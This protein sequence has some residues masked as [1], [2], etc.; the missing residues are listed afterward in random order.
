MEA[1]A[2]PVC[3]ACGAKVRLPKHAPLPPPSARVKCPTCSSVGE[4]EAFIRAAAGVD[5]S[6]MGA[7]EVA[8]GPPVET[9]PN[10][11]VPRPAG[12]DRARNQ[13]GSQAAAV[14]EEGT[15]ISGSATELSLP[16]G[17]RCSL[18]ILSGPDRGRKITID[19]PRIVVGRENGDLPLTDKEVSREHCAFEI[20]GV[21]CRVIDLGSRNG[22]W[23][24]G[25]KVATE[26]LPNVGE[27][28]VGNTTIL[29]TMTLEDSIQPG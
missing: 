27:V 22:T 17:L 4:L 29:F 20:A 9:M 26:E 15:R 28:T 23:V 25:R 12:T 8:D 5:D 11:P 2:G 6:G 18:T 13:K 3:P 14:A 24:D 21:T 7:P 10:V 19:R 16:P 1:V